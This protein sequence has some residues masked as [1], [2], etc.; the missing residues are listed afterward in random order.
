[1][2]EGGQNIGLKGL[3]S[4]TGGSDD[5]GGSDDDS[6]KGSTAT[7]TQP[8][9]GGSDHTPDGGGENSPKHLKTSAYNPNAV[10]S[11]AKGKARQVLNQAATGVKKVAPTPK[12][13]KAKK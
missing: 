9:Q 2:S 10:T 3:W 13:K 11:G 1:M 12:A 4:A 7:T 8:N 5:S 6:S